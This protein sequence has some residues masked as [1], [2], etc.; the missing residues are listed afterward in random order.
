MGI[1]LWLSAQSAHQ[2]VAAE[3]GVRSL[4]EFHE[5]RGLSA[6]T[7]N[8][9]PYGDF[10]QTVVKHK[11]YE[12]DW[13]EEE[14]FEYTLTLV[15]ILTELLPEMGEGSISTL[16][17][18]WGKAANTRTDIDK[19]VS[20]ILRLSEHL[21]ENEIESGKLIHVDLE[22]E[23]GCYLD[24]CGDVI[25]FF[26]ERLFREGNE[27]LVQR[28]LRV[29]YDI[30]HS[31]VMFEDP[32]VSLD[33]YRSAGIRIGKAQVSSALK[34]NFEGLGGEAREE[35]LE[36]LRGFQEDRYLHQT[37]IREGPGGF[38]FFEDLP[39]AL[40]SLSEGAG[41]SGEWRVHFHV[42]LFL[43]RAG[44]I[45]TTQE[46]IP[47]VLPLLL[48]SGVKHFEVETYAWN[49]LPESL[50]AVGLADGIAKE[51]E[52]LKYQMEW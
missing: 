19:A 16:P 25:D 32:T 31:A 18:G 29:C 30:C 24:R 3:Y 7:L 28:Y 2:T 8:G 44:N 26:K 39:A 33:R 42:P 6:F 1:G 11:V 13:G 46:Q 12:P 14:R 5:E 43:E 27:E 20:L 22:P 45:G 40:A 38:R 4:K 23:P 21:Q 35:T 50:R 48:A 34:A 36:R 41:P 15:S 49:V 52:W 17:I 10:H 51:L 9:F 37:V 47:Q